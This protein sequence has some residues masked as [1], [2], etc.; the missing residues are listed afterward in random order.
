MNLALKREYPAALIASAQRVKDLG[1]NPLSARLPR[2]T[3]SASISRKVRL[4]AG[5]HLYFTA[6]FLFVSVW[7]GVDV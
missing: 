7:L 1:L 2:R 4:R 3:F 6:F 5:C